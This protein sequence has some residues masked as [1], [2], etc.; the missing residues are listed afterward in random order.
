MGLRLALAQGSILTLAIVGMAV[1]MV[2]T[3]AALAPAFTPSDIPFKKKKGKNNYISRRILGP[4]KKVAL[5]FIHFDLNKKKPLL[6][7]TYMAFVSKSMRSLE[8]LSNTKS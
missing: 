6:C 1:A 3:T 4:P 8:Y 2:A 7:A 5:Y